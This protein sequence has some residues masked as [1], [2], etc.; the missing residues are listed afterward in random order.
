[1]E[2][3]LAIFHA[4]NME[5]IRDRGTLV[6]NL[7]FPVLLVFGFA[8][9]FGGG[10]DTVFTVGY[11]GGTL[12]QAG[13]QAE[14]FTLD[15]IEFVQYDQLSRGIERVRYH[16]IDMLVDLSAGEYFVNDSATNG[17]L[18]ER[19]LQGSAGELFAKEAVTGRPIRY[20]DFIVPGII[21]M[22]MM[23]SGVFGVGFV[24]VRYRKNG[25][26]KRLKATPVG[27]FQFVSAQVASRFMIVVITSV[28]VFAAT[29][30]FLN[31]LMLGSYLLLLLLTMIA[32]FCMIS[33][34]LIFATRIKSEELASGLMNI[35]TLP[36]LLLSGVFFSLEG[37]PRILQQ[38]SRA[39]P[40]THFVEGARSIMLDGAGVVDLLPNFAIL[41]GFT[42]LF[43]FA[44]SLL[45]RWE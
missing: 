16:Q 21:G 1:M 11:Y 28:V 45:F 38:V 7:L 9:A 25:V 6:W 4:R 32:V 15:H 2:K 5:F 13:A 35:I 20:V 26:L 27:A 14:F 43:L 24:L 41:G 44:A 36:M 39:F 37:T 3:F 42:I 33:L 34:G 40:L 23:F 10:S 18:V 12:E 30:F 29:N 17:Y 22:N 8:F 19:L 31:F